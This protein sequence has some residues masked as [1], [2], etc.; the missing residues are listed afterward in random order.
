MARPRGLLVSRVVAVRVLVLLVTL[1]LVAFGG[2][3]STVV[4]RIAGASQQP[5]MN[6]A[7]TSP[8]PDN[9]AAPPGVA[10]QQRPGTIRLPRGGAAMV[11]RREITADG[12][13]PVPEGVE[14]ATWWGAG[15]DAGSGATV[16]AGHVNWKGTTGPFAELWDASKGD[17]V[18]VVDAAERTRQ[19]RVSEVITLHK[20]EVPQQALTLFGQDGPHRVVLVTCGGRWVGGQLGYETNRIVVAQP[21]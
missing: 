21:A 16:F 20:D 12:T 19:Y 14:E 18:A 11:V 17:V 8:Q 9:D 3:A 1:G 7:A 6:D 15:L 13:L 10:E 5:A 4:H 2:A